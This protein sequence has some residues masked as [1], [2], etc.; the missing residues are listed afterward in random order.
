MFS[1]KALAIGTAVAASVGFAMPVASQAAP[2]AA[3]VQIQTNSDSHIVNIGNKKKSKR[4][5]SRHCRVSNDVKCGR[6]YTKKRYRSYKE[7]YYGQY[8]PYRK[9]GVTIQ[10]D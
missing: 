10:I 2:V 8:R 3:P 9:P 7:P 5:W 6:Y 1:I 4:W